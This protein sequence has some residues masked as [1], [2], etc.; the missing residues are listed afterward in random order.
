M[1]IKN[2]SAVLMAI[3]GM[4]AILFASCGGGGNSAAGETINGLVVPPEPNAI[5]NNSTLAGID[6][7]NN[8]VRDDIERQIAQASTTPAQFDASIRL[9]HAYQEIIVNS[10]PQLRDGGLELEKAIK[11]S[12]EDQVD[13]PVSLRNMADKSMESLLFNTE[14]RK[15]KLHALHTLIGGYDSDEV[16]CGK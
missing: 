10:T 12:N 4:C 15:D 7:N 6:I 2:K 16:S 11:C 13:I 3:A 9:A 5:A 1:K 8:G 14:E